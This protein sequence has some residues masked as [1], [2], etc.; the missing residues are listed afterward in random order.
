[1]R[2]TV[3]HQ[4]VPVGVVDLDID[5]H[6]GVGTLER[7][8]AYES[9]AP[10]L[11]VAAA[12]GARARTELLTLDAEGTPSLPGLEKAAALTFEVW[13]ERGV[14]VPTAVVRLVELK[15]RPGITVFVEFGRTMSSV[16]AEPPLRR[17]SAPDAHRLP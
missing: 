3:T 15:T 7:A 2:L 17:G 16:P 9:I 14:Y 4:G 13:D 11:W 5:D 6:Q 8:P 10:V 1:M 12:Q